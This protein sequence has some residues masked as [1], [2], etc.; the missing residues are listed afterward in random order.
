VSFSFYRTVSNLNNLV[1]DTNLILNNGSGDPPYFKD[2]SMHW[3]IQTVKR[4]NMLTIIADCRVVA[5]LKADFSKISPSEFECVS[6][7]AGD[8]YKISY[9]IIMDFEAAIHFRLDFNGMFRRLVLGPVLIT[10]I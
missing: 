8:Y 7:A 10:G 4:S 1:F 6:S 3:R 2:D 5:T 9:N